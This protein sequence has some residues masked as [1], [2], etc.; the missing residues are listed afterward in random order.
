MWNEEKI[1]DY[2][3]VHLKENRFQHTMGVVKVAEELCEIYGCSKEKAKLAALLHDAAKYMDD[4]SILEILKKENIKID[5]NIEKNL[6]LMHG[7]CGSYIAK[8][9]MG[10]EDDEVL[11]AIKYHT[12]G[13]QNMNLLEKIIYLSDFIEE[14]RKYDGVEELR[15]LCKIDLNRA[16]LKAF[17]NT[18]IYVIKQNQFIHMDTINARN[19]LI[20]T[21]R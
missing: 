20:K 10:V 5:S 1:V 13:K 8:E 17:D 7:L 19:Y 4:K 3:K 9:I 16:L 18:I 11:G 14:N 15:T 2:L 12:T 6:S 21:M